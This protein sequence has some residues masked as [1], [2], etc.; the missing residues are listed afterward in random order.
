MSYKHYFEPLALKEYVDALK[1]YKQR[2]VA[3]SI[4]FVKEMDAAIKVICS[5][6]QKFRTTYKQFRETALKKYPFYIIY[7]IDE[8]RKQ[9]IIFSAFHSKRNPLKKYPKK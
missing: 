5:D 6:P 2:S 3:A 1:W 7:S 9:V 8:S 4:N